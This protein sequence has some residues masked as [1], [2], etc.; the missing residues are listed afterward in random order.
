MHQQFRAFRAFLAI[1]VAFSWAAVFSPLSLWGA[2]PPL[3]ATEGH[4]SFYKHT[5]PSDDTYTTNPSP[6]TVTFMNSHWTR[7]LTYGGYWNVGNKLSW[8]RNAWTY[9]DAYAI[10]TDPTN[11]TYANLIAAHP[12]WI[13]RD[14]KGNPLYIP[15]ACSG[16][17]CP[18][19]AAD[20]TNP[21]GFRAWWLSQVQG[22]FSQTPPFKGLFIDDVNLDLSR[23]SDGN[24][25]PVTPIDPNTGTLMTNTAWRTYFADFMEQV[26][27]ALPGIEIAHN[28]LWFWDWTDSN[29]QRE[30]QAADWINLERGVND[31]GLT[32]GTGFWS[33]YRLWQFVDNVH[34]DG[35]G[36]ILDGEVPLSATDPAREYSAAN[37]LLISTGQDMVG[38]ASE[39]PTNWWPGFDTDL[40]AA[41]GARYSWNNLWRRDFAGGMALV[42]PP[43]ASTVVATLPQSFVRTDG[44][45][46]NSISLNGGEGA[47]LSSLPNIT[48]LSP[49]SATAGGSGFT[50]TVNG[51]NFVSG[52]SVKWGS[53]ALSTTYVSA[54]RVTAAVPASLIASAGSISVTVTT[55]AGTSG[56]ATFTITGGGPTITSLSPSS[57]TAGG[58]GF[59]LTVN[60]TSFVSGASVQWGSTG[61]TTTFVSATQ[62]TAA[63][64]A[65]LIANAGAASITVKTAAGTSPAATFTITA[66]VSGGTLTGAVTTSAGGVNLTSEGPGD[67]VHWGDASLNRE[68]GVTAQLSNYTM[69]GGGS[70][71]RYPNDP[72]PISWTAGTPT[73]TSTNNTWGLY[74]NGTGQGFS[75]TAPASTSAQTLIVHAGG[76]SSAGTLTAHLS[77]GSAADYV[78]VSP[79]V[80]GQYDRNYTISYRA[81]G[82]ST[83]TVS[84]VMSSGGGNVT[85]NAAALS[86]SSSAPT[87][88]A[89]GGT[90]QSTA[91]NT[92]FATALQVTAKDASGNPMSG[93]TV[94]FTAPSSGASAAF[95]GSR[96]ATATTNGSG[97]ATAPTLTANGLTGSYTVSATSSAG[98]ATF[99]LTNTGGAAASVAATSGTPQSAATGTVFATALQ[100]TVKD[101]GGNPV[102]GVTVTFTAPASGASASFGGSSTASVATNASGVANAPALTANSVAGT[103][104]VTASVSGISATAP[105]NLTNTASVGASLAGT[106]TTSATG[107]NL[108]S[109]GSTDWVHWGDSSLNRKAGVSAQLSSYTLLGGGSAS[110]YPNDPR[111]IS[112]T[113]GTPTASSTN[114]TWGVYSN[115]TGHGFSFTAPASTSTRTLIVHTGGYNSGGTLTAHLSDNSAPDFVDV[116]PTVSGQYDRNYTITYRAGSTATLTVSWVMSAGGGNVTLN[117]AALP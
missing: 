72:R 63:V 22:L 108:S 67:W 30:I 32:G 102:S 13:L 66:A 5:G 89:T 23:V 107:V 10:Y 50:L 38:D 49:S 7:L 6:A 70:A 37:Y 12:N 1:I 42:N 101:A 35:K 84:W 61:L 111:P 74:A 64:P 114:N 17:T 4:V 14:S 57:A 51:T 113:G 46:V 109:E 77:D 98:S 58:S 104:T 75:F 110:P 96:T 76:Y 15:Y 93:V 105:F 26:R 39:T 103:Y 19:Y 3:A 94:T 29:I 28:S 44:S 85:L 45:V 47:V 83:L 8:Y 115:G 21:N 25:N 48:S 87:L 99:S 60:G 43:G 73:A 82:A 52:A 100:A 68:A 53:T 112:W 2:T 11:T 71:A 65:S 33:L 78:D 95:G 59:T 116:S 91:I 27:A 90:P 62:L 9:E 24:G 34:A 69:V 56:P 40:G 106:V 31:S 97:I 79:L 86:G 117:A 55:P 92:A 36:V 54:S 41:Q 88:T 80:S 20:I 16:G 81:S 18:E